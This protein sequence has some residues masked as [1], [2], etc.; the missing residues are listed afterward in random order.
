MQGGG[1]RAQVEPVSRLIFGLVVLI[2][3][4]AC[5]LP[6]SGATP[7]AGTPAA[8]R[9]RYVELKERLANSPFHRPLALYSQ[10]TDEHLEGDIYAVIDHPIQVVRNAL[11]RASQWCEVLIL[12]LNIQYCRGGSRS[13]HT[14]TLRIGRKYL[15]PLSDTQR[16]EFA[17]RV[18]ADSPE[19]LE[20]LLNSDSGP[21]GTGDYRISL[22]GIPLD[23]THTFLHFSYSYAYGALA[24]IA[25]QVYL[26][27]YGRNKVG[28]SVLGKEPNGLPRYTKG[29]RG[30]VER[31]A[32]RYYLA[33]DA[34][35][36]ALSA[37]SAERPE[38]SMRA[39]FQDTERYALQ[40]H[41]L[42][43]AQYLATKRT[44]YRRQEAHQ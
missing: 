12:H 26:A 32:M 31:N 34:Y 23:T 2:L 24:R 16:L 42:D 5:S 35:L 44:Q 28:F 38:K 41:E 10:D 25:M 37:P 6:A 4:Q 3:W 1:V 9:E 15:Q 22:A 14:L 30:I 39:W 7:E 36:G 33:I 40:L 13:G 43:E 17:Y 8:L 27:T 19:Y 20:L 29:L 11:V 18:A 21:F